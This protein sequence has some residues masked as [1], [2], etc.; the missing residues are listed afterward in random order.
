MPPR[1]HLNPI[2]VSGV[3]DMNSIMPL[4]FMQLQFPRHNQQLARCITHTRLHSTYC[5]FPLLT[6]NA[7]Q[8]NNVEAHFALNR[9]K[10][11][12]LRTSYREHWSGKQSTGSNN[13]GNKKRSLNWIGIFLLNNQ[14]RCLWNSCQATLIRCCNSNVER[15]EVA[16]MNLPRLWWYLSKSNSSIILSEM[17]R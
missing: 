10:A 3:A 14:R 8:L 12:K 16:F 4:R 15:F 9:T 17:L 11:I 6:I 5:R 13:T 2:D 7:N 1:Y